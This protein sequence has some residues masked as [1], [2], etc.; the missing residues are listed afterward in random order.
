MTNYILGEAI[1]ILV[2]EGTDWR[3][4]QSNWVKTR[5]QLLFGGLYTGFQGF[6][7]EFP[8]FDGFQDGLQGL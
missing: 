1:A 4:C 2:L 8:G 7:I 6:Q 5:T 3:T